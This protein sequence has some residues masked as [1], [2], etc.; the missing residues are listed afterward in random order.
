MCIVE[1]L[2]KSKANTILT[3][4]IELVNNFV[5][6]TCFVP[7]NVHRGIVLQDLIV[8]IKKVMLVRENFFLFIFFSSFN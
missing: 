5:I 2:D 8:L 1:A 4:L 3:S 7:Q 6:N